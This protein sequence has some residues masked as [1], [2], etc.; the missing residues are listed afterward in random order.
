MRTTLNLDDDV[1]AAARDLARMQRRP[2][3]EVISALARQA[4]SANVVWP[5]VRNGIPLLPRAAGATTVT[6][7]MVNRLRDQSP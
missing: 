5:D 1:L 7:A 2:L 6:L 4:L 3:G